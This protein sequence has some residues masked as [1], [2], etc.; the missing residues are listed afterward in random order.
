MLLA[1][2]MLLLD[3]KLDGSPHGAA[4]RAPAESNRWMAAAC[5]AELTALG[6]L[7]LVGQDV[8]V[9]NDLAANYMLL[10]DALAVLRRKPQNPQGC[11]DLVARAMPRIATD[12][13]AS[14]ALRGLLIEQ[15]AKRFGLFKSL[16]Y[17][18]QSTSAYAE[19]IKLLDAGIASLGLQNLWS[20]AFVL[21]ADGMG[22]LPALLPDLTLS[23]DTQLN[24]FEA[25][26]STSRQ[27]SDP[28]AQRARLIFQLTRTEE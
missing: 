12:L 1:E 2:H 21:L 7:Q 9:V 11:V 23:L 6:R 15:S 27:L 24:R 8:H 22:I 14:M 25:Y 18:V 13:L 3:R 26:I 19:S 16:S 17:P 28:N 20:M 5:V 4:A 10:N